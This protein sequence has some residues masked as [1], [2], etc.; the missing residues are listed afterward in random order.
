MKATAPVVKALPQAAP[1]V[2]LDEL[3]RIIAAARE[4][5]ALDDDAHRHFAFDALAVPGSAW[6]LR[7]RG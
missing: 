1:S 7:Y 6:A 5:G 4:T 3:L 2:A